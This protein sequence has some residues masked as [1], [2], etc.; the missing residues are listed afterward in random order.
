MDGGRLLRN[1]ANHAPATTLE[2]PGPA[3]GF[4][5]IA[6]A[7]LP[8]GDPVRNLLLRFPPVPI[9][10]NPDLAAELPD[11]NCIMR[12]VVRQTS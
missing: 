6:L 9:T 7:A 3:P 11:S 12:L 8:E 5:L 2:D 1:I 4:S 10:L